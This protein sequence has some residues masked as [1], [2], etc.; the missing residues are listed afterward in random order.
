MSLSQNGWRWTIMSQKISE[1][2]KISPIGAF[3]LPHSMELGVGALSIH[4]IVSQY[5]GHD[6]WIPV[7]LFGLSTVG[8]MWMAFRLLEKERANGGS[9]I[10]SINQRFFGR[11]LGGAMN[12]IPLIY[13]ALFGFV[14]LRSYIQI[15]QIWIFPQLP[16]WGYVIIYCLMVWYIVIGGIRTVTGISLL[17]FFFMLPVFFT[18]L[19]S[20]RGAHYANILPMFDHGPVEILKGFKACTHSY[21]GCPMVFFFYPFLKR[22][23]RA[24][25]W[26]Y[27]SL[28]LMTYTYVTMMI[29]GLLYF[30]QGEIKTLVWP[31]M[32]YWKTFVPI[33]DSVDVFFVIYWLWILLPSTCFAAWAL[34][35]GMKRVFYLKQK[36]ALVFVLIG[37]ICASEWVRDAREIN[38]L[39]K[40]FAELGFYTFFVYIPFLFVYQWIF[41]KVRRKNA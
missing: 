31:T 24:E 12:V 19:T 11:W 26:S 37:F 22:P 34:S 7:L 25:K 30:S 10:F 29:L 17:S 41:Y 36:H 38:W 5:S 32:S 13:L 16:T 15:L 4:R 40:V 18:F 20:V 39:T 28:L 21:L 6:A 14:L 9:D 33:L 27:F 1:A 8:L 35:R 23:E 3:F 2:N